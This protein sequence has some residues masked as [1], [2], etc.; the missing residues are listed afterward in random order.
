VVV[1]EEEKE[2]EEVGRYAH[3]NHGIG[4]TETKEASFIDIDLRDFDLMP[5]L[6]QLT[7]TL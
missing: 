2:E 4:M 5:T 1:V 6:H 3:A 7:P